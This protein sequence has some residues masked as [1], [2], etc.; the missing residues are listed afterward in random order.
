MARRARRSRA[1]RRLGQEGVGLARAAGEPGWVAAVPA[2]AGAGLDGAQAA[3]VAVAFDPGGDL[4][5]ARAGG[6][7]RGPRRE[8]H[9]AG[10]RATG[11]DPEAPRQLD[12]DLPPLVAE[13][14]QQAGVGGS[15]IRDADG[16]RTPAEVEVRGEPR[17][18]GPAAVDRQECLPLLDAP[19]AGGPTGEVGRWAPGEPDLLA[20]DQLLASGRRLELDREGGRRSGR[21]QQESGGQGRGE[22]EELRGHGAGVYSK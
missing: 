22:E 12:L 15:Q 19:E 7:G 9:R 2:A 21:A 10:R 1:A 11:D 20:A 13:A 14:Q 3:T 16:D 5:L 8:R 17:G 18:P 6:F 4:G